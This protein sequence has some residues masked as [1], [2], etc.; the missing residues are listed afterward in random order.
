[1]RPNRTGFS[2]IELMIVTAILGLLAAVAIPRLSKPDDQTRD[3]E[4]VAALASLRTAIDSYWSQHAAFP[5]ELGPDQL[6]NQLCRQTNDAGRP[7]VGADYL[8]GPYLPTG[9][10]PVS[11]IVGRNNI[12]V[13]DSIPAQP[14]GPEA[15]LYDRTSGEVRAN[16]RGTTAGGDRYFD[17]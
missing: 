1:M 10:M 11:P 5:G 13:V 6:V 14:T 17:L 2:I 12:Q 15:W 4:V 9:R 3:A 8:L 16:S 7:G